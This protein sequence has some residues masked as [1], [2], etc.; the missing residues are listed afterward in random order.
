MHTISAYRAPMIDTP[1]MHC[2]KEIEELIQS[3]PF[4]TY[5]KCKT[6]S[7]IRLFLL[8]MGCVTGGKTTTL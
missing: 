4:S 5:S 8:L 6:G 3:Q 2:T 7:N 1:T